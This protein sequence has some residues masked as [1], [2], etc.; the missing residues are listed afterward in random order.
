MHTSIQLAHVLT[1]M[2]SRG[3]GIETAAEAVLAAA[4]KSNRMTTRGATHNM[5]TSIKLAHVL[6]WAYRQRGHSRSGSGRNN[7]CASACICVAVSRT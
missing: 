7:M 6:T 4:G 1:W 3:G 2:F 5:H